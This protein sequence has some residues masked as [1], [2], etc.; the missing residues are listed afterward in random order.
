MANT[1]TNNI[2]LTAGLDIGNGFV[3][4]IV[5]GYDE[6]RTVIDIPS[7][8]ALYTNPSNIK[9]T[10]DEVDAVI[11]DIFNRM[12]ATINSHLVNSGVRRLFGER[13]RVS[14]CTLEE[15]DVQ[16]SIS[17]A[18]QPLSAILILG[19]LAG[20]AL[21]QYWAVNHAFPGETL[22]CH[23]DVGLALPIT[24][25]KLHREGYAASLKA[26]SHLVTIENFEQPVRIEIFIDNAR[27]VAEGQSAQ[28][29]ILAAG[30]G[31]INGMLADCRRNGDPLEG[32]TAADIIG[33]KNSIGID[34]GEGT[35]NFPV[36]T[37]GSFNADRSR[38]LGHGYGT[39]LENV[40]LRLQGQGIPVSGRKDILA[41][42]SDG[43]TV[44]NRAIYPRVVEA[45]N[46]E[47][48]G[49][50]LE[51][52]HTVRGLL[53]NAGLMAGVIYVYGGGS[54]P[55]KEKL[56]R[57]LIEESKRVSLSGHPVLYLDA[58]WSRMLNVEGMYLVAQ[59]FAATGK[60]K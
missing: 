60:K 1:N 19:C 27:V 20:K 43:E 16:T 26:K 15:F 11:G 22:I 59:H 55:L 18:Q 34:I 50:I 33:V 7:V 17:K 8:S 45:L 48:D 3:K 13:A 46:E 32:I 41:Y 28:Y 29:A 51:I 53:Q 6:Q 23:A 31:L 30:E 38:T 21:Q 4:A 56:H 12:E 2:H 57:A 47:S 5:A 39:V 52:L 54:A 14:G 25:Y 35:V 9:T 42:L 40:K 36:F 44:F 37:G 10:P 49:F 24:E 58:S